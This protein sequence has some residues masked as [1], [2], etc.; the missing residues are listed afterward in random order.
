[1]MLMRL[2]GD[3]KSW[4]LAWLLE[5]KPDYGLLDQAYTMRIHLSNHEQ[6]RT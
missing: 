4:L 2:T 3:P 5:C 6:I 1:M